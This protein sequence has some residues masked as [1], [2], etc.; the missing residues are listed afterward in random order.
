M[1]NAG[2]H[3]ENQQCWRWQSY[4]QDNFPYSVPKSD[5]VVP[6]MT[7]DL[8]S[9]FS[10]PDSSI[11][12]VMLFICCDC[13]VGFSWRTLTQTPTVNIIRDNIYIYRW[14]SVIHW[15]GSVLLL[16]DVSHLQYVSKHVN[17]IKCVI[18][19][20][21]VQ[22]KNNWCACWCLRGWDSTCDFGESIVNGTYADEAPMSCNDLDE[23]DWILCDSCWLIWSFWFKS[24]WVI[25]RSGSWR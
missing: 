1:A 14:I 16:H 23:W 10:M 12:R 15:N 13:D 20:H 25:L 22:K 21:F 6:S 24:L 11:P 5:D 18:L 19:F 9:S 7:T 3:K 8:A 4:H 2:C 17:Q